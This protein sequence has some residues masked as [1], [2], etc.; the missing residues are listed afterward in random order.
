MLTTAQA[1]HFATFGFAVL[2]GFLADRVAAL[3]A[4]ADAAIRDAYAATYDERVIDGISGH[5]LPMAARLT[6]V[7]ASLVCD[8]PRFIDA[9]G[10]LLGGLVI[11]ECPEGVLY[12]AEAGWHT[13]DGI[14]VRGVKFA[15]YFEP[16]TA[17]NGALRLVPGSH[18][19]EQNAR[20]AAYRDR[21]LPI[22]GDAVAAA[23]RASIP[24]YVV[25]TVPGDVIA[26]DLHAW[27]ASFGGRDRLAWT[28]VYQRCPET[29]AERDRTLRSAHDSFEQA[30]RGFDRDRYP[31]WRDWLA[32]AAAHPRRAP[33]I[34]RMRQ[35]GI[36]DLPGAQDGW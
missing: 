12:F 25:A 16:L 23:Y 4:E 9:A 21:Q 18:H 26:F 33:V 27:H 28:A 1:D 29:A 5:Y 34:D 20:L 2:R 36:L 7:S 10:Q 24:G 19:P 14:G 13:D 3:R 31:V 22:R 8:D 30:F 35:A 11:P 15:A 32:D 6:P 17:G